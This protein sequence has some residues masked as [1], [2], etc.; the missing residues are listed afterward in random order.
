MRAQGSGEDKRPPVVELP[1]PRNGGHRPRLA[2]AS[3]RLETAWWEG[4]A[5][6]RPV[7]TRLRY[8]RLARLLN[9]AVTMRPRP[10]V[11][12]LPEVSIPRAW[13]RSA[14]KLVNE[15]GIT[16]VAGAEYG[17][18]AR[19]SGATSAATGNITQ[20]AVISATDRR[21]GYPSV[22]EIWQN[23]T[24]P[25][26]GEHEALHVRFGRQWN[27]GHG[28]HAYPADAKPLY[29]HRGLVFGLVICSELRNVNYRLAFQSNVDLL[30]VP[31]SNR[32]LRSFEALVESAALDVHAYIGLVNDGSYG[33]TRVRVPARKQHERDVCRV[34]GGL[35]DYL[36]VAELDIAG[37][38][39]F[40]SRDLD[41]PG[42][43]DRFKPVPDGF[44]ISPNRRRI[45][46]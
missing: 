33:D 26:P 30:L 46:S 16:L 14:A 41:W 12:V 37:L 21:L 32:D 5:A 34:R 27:G 45:P 38:R 1:F 13:V 3:M 44:E 10:D 25:A 36:V 2:V 6:G 4:S 24:K 7:L 23:K 17:H 9:Q 19:L 20:Q 28:V 42:K 22:T 31:A 29:R 43:A 11:L 35:N 8:S 40:Q 18:G 39:R 15:A